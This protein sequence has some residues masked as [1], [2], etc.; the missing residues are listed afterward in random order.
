[1]IKIVDASIVDMLPCS[2]GVIFSTKQMVS[3]GKYKVSFHAVD[4]KKLKSAPI[5]RSVYLRNKFGSGYRRIVSE[6]GDYLSCDASPYKEDSTVIVYPTGE[7]GIFNAEGKALW[8]G[9][10]LYHDSP[11][12]SIIADGHLLWC[13]VPEQN[14]IISYSLSHKKFHMRIGGKNSTAFQNPTSL[15]KYGNELFVCCADANKIR[16]VNLRDFSVQDFRTFD[17]PVYRYMRVCGKEIVQL[18]SGVYI[19]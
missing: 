18:E 15:K 13:T 3:E 12:Q 10:L 8:V 17:E 9:D 4:V 7:T 1:M 11:I 14:S 6:I 2:G 5:I 19:L 16:T